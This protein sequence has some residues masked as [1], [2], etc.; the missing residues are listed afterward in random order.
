MKILIVEDDPG[1]SA[2]VREG[3]DEAGYTTQVVRD[4]AR[5]LKVAETGSYS[6]IILDLMLPAMDGLEICRRLR[7]ARKNVPI[8]MVT[9]RDA[10]PERIAGLEAGADDYLVKPFEFN[11]LLAR[12]RALLRREHSI[13]QSRIEVDDLVVDTQ[14]RTVTRGAREILLTAREYKLLEAFA[15]HVGRTLTRESIQERVWVDEVSVSNTVHV[16]VKNLRKKI[17]DIAERKLIHTVHRVGYVM[18]TEP[19]S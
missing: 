14:N 17:D 16:C 1:M 2:A 4:G 8:L 18:R 10:V 19:P 13:K 7:H 9:A 5:A 11:E 6:V 3:L 12:V 15:T